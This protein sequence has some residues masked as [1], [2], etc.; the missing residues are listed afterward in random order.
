M[1]GLSTCDT[2][3]GKVSTEAKACPHCGQPNPTSGD[4]HALVLAL[5]G[6]KINA[7]KLVRDRTGWSLTQAKQFVDEILH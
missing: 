7:I 2:C 4:L 6:N 1:A 3:N 5:A